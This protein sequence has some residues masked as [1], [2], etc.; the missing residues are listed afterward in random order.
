MRNATLGMATPDA[1]VGLESAESAG[2]VGAGKVAGTVP[3]LAPIR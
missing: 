2:D 3:G 1:E